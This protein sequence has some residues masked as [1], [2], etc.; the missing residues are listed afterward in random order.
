MYSVPATASLHVA[1]CLLTS[2]GD[3]RILLYNFA[4]GHSGLKTG[5][6]EEGY[7]GKE[8]REEELIGCS[9]CGSGTNSP[10]HFFLECPAL[11]RP[12][13]AMLQGLEKAVPGVRWE[14]RERQMEVILYGVEETTAALAIRDAVETFVIRARS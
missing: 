7:P 6:E 13:T 2:C 8:E 5:E 3:G 1:A 14:R 9:L 4:R 10:E 11:A 12:R